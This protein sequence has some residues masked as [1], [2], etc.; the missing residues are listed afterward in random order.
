MQKLKVSLFFLLKIVINQFP[1]SS[2]KCR[3]SY[4]SKSLIPLNPW[5]VAR[6]KNQK[7]WPQINKVKLRIAMRVKVQGTMHPP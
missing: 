7:F 1:S 6:P 4:F 3:P 2:L 5:R